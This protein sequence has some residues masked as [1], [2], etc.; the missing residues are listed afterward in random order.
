MNRLTMKK[1]LLTI[2][3][4]ISIPQLQAQNLVVNPDAESLPGGTGWNVVSQGALTCLLVPTSNMI[5]WTMKPN[6]TVNY[7]FDHTT[8]ANGGTVFFSGCDT[9]LTGPFELNQTIDVSADSALINAGSQLFDFSGYMQTPVDNQTDIGRFIVDFVDG[10]NTVLGTSYTTNWQSSFGGSGTGWIQYTN[11]RIAPPG[12]KAVVIRLQTQMIVNQPAINVYFDDISLIKTTVVPLGLLS[13][14]GVA[15]AGNAKLNWKMSPGLSC[16]QFELERST[17]VT[18]FNRIASIP[19]T[20]KASYEFTDDNINPVNDT[21]FYRLKMTGTDGKT[22]YSGIVMVKT[23]GN[24][25]IGLYPNPA[26]NNV[27]INGLQEPGKLSVINCNGSTVL[28]TTVSS[29][30]AKLNVSGLPGGLYV[31][32]FNNGKNTVTKKLVIRHS[33]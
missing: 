8:G 31:V 6:G 21:Y 3:T 12:T 19:V 14:T 24:A 26:N 2:S 15:G 23:T 13:F 32:R 28:K 22:A 10:S 4:L 17:D 16:K 25:F 11:T 7:P 18:Y 27:T 30:T 1:I 5:N 9:Y 33:N 20:G 29:A